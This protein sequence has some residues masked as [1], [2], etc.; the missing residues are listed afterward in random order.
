MK[1]AAKTFI[2][3]TLACTL[4]A[5]AAFAADRTPTPSGK[6]LTPQQQKMSDCNQGAKA[7]SLK[8]PE[9]KAFMSECLKKDSGAAATPAAAKPAAAATAAATPAPAATPAVTQ[10][11]KM[12]T[13]NADPQAKTLK[14]DDRKKFMSTCLSA[15]AAAH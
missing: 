7:Q 5:S 8:G 10:Q 3:F 15:P 13:C 6:T 1:F 9:Y 2:A 14:G 4:G 12:K 11:Q